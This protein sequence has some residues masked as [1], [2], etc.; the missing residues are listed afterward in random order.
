[1]KMKIVVLWA[2]RIIYCAALALLFVVLI[3]RLPLGESLR[4][5]EVP[6]FYVFVASVVLAVVPVIAFLRSPE[7]LSWATTAFLSIMF[8]WYGWF[9]LGAPF[10]LHELHTFDPVEAA[11]EINSHRVQALAGTVGVVGFIMLLPI[12]RHFNRHKSA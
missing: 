5:F 3:R 9:S 2:Y 4:R 1:V 8:I 11:R 10:V 6:L 7:W 12:L